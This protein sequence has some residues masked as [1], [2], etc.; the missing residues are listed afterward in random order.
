MN[1]GSGVSILPRE[2][3]WLRVVSVPESQSLMS[4]RQTIWSSSVDKLL[5]QQRAK[6]YIQEKLSIRQLVLKAPVHGHTVT[7]PPG[8]QCISLLCQSLGTE[9]GRPAISLSSTAVLVDT[10]SSASSR[11]DILLLYPAALI[12]TANRLSPTASQLS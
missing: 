8:S 9:S 7:Q 6:I 12:A 11:L 1:W 4:Y 5:Q 3:T 10:P 2:L